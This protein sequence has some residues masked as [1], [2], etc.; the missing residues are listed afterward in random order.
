MKP[1]LK[2]NKLILF[3][4]IFFNILSSFSY[5]FIAILLQKIM[6]TVMNKNIT[7]FINITIFSII[8]FIILGILLYLQSLLS[9]KV[10]DKII[11]SIRLKLFQGIINNSIEEYEKLKTADYLSIINNDVKLLEDNYLIPVFEIIQY[12]IIFIASLGIMIY[13]DITV[14]IFVFIAIS[15]MFIVPSIFAKRLENCQKL[16]SQQL[17][18]FTNILKDLLTGFEIIKSYSIYNHALTKFNKSNK[19]NIDSKYTVDKLVALNEGISATLALLIQVLVII[20]SSYFIITGRLTVG[21]LLG[22]VQASSNLANPL[23]MIFSNL[24]K[25][26]SV[27]PI[28]SKLEKFTKQ[29]DFNYKKNGPS[30]FE[31]IY[32]NNLS[33]SYNNNQKILKNISININSGKKYVIVGKSGC[34]KTTLIKLLLGYYSNYEGEIY[35]DHTKLSQINNISHLSSLIHQNIYLFNETIYDNICLHETYSSNQINY[36]LKQSG[37]SQFINQLPNRLLYEIKENGANLSGGQRQRVA[38]ARALIRNK[39][40]LILDESTSSIDKQTA[41]D[42]EKNLLTIKNLTLLTITH[43]LDKELLKLYDTII[44]MDAGKII[45]TGSY[46]VLFNKKTSFYKFINLD[47]NTN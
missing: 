37:L 44:F 36:V 6:N 3:F 16:Y 1:Y 2:Q 35:Y 8:Y 28:I 34:G 18:S 40:L 31:H 12:T 5:V 11:Y 17:S 23:L 21:S 13:F 7:G 47:N 46:D 9:K 42:I 19:K 45:E 20:L 24:P 33:F 29:A 14:T 38:V 26:K 32:I 25:I 22:M 15:I 43:N 39:P 4:A 41:Y 10:I 30:S 27:K